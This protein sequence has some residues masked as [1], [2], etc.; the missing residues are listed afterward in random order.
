MKFEDL[1]F[2][3]HGIFT[4]VSFVFFIGIVWWTYGAHRNADFD[5]AANLPFADEPDMLD[6]ETQHG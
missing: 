6:R 2:N 5:G 1:L 3:A 4:L